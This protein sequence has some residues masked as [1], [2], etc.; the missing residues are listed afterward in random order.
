MTEVPKYLSG[1]L[2]G[3]S[4]CGACGACGACAACTI[5]LGSPIQ[6]AWIGVTDAV[7]SLLY[8]VEPIEPVLP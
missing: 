4:A 1:G 6:L 8:C 5:C 2:P 7:M 3:I